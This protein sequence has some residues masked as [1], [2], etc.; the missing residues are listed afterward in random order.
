[1]SKEKFEKQLKEAEGQLVALKRV[2]A[3]PDEIEL[4]E[5]E[6]KELQEKIKSAPTT[7]TPTSEKKVEPAKRSMVAIREAKGVKKTSDAKH[8]E[9]IKKSEPSKKSDASRIMKIG[10][11]KMI[12]PIR[13]ERK[14]IP[15]ERKNTHID[16]KHTRVE[17]RGRK[18][19][20]NKKITTRKSKG[21]SVLFDGKTYHDT[22]PNFC[23]ILIKQLEERKKKRAETGG[24][25]KTSS[26]S[27]KVGDNIASSVATAIKGA[28]KEHKEE[29]LDN[30]ASANKFLKTI[31]RIESAADKFVS[32]MKSILTDRFKQKDF[33]KEFKEV[34]EVIKKIKETIKKS[35]E[36]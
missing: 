8:I 31:D 23:E 5:D 36:K 30:K 19:L 16:N 12:K 28:F 27:A 7:S 26:L 4:I 2:K 21:L 33:D 20:G 3:S 17:T 1:M 35:S 9:P 10:K 14:P 25:V 22:D 34:D 15:V 11:R 29:I 6:I 24:K 13:I 32:E 18:P